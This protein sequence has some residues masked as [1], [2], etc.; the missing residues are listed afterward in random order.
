MKL[1]SLQAAQTRPDLS[2]QLQP[3]ASPMQRSSDVRRQLDG[4]TTLRACQLIFH[5]L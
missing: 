5:P 3:P 2:E 1:T 4:G